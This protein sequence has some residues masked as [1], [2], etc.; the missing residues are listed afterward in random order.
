MCRASF[1][2]NGIRFIRERYGTGKG[3]RSE[4][5]NGYRHY[6]YGGHPKWTLQWF[7]VKRRVIVASTVQ[8][9]PS[10]P[11]SGS[12]RWLAGKPTTSEPTSGEL[13]SGELTSGEPTSGELTSGEPTSGE[14][15]SGELTTGELTGDGLASDSLARPGS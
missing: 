6:D 3:G 1:N 15:T 2:R 7:T 4:H 13:T 9:L 11:F 5:C 10:T 14:P 12:C 8:S